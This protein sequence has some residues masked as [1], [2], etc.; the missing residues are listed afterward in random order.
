MRKKVIP[1]AYPIYIAAAVWAVCSL[2]IH[3]NTIVKLLLL[4][5][6]AAAGYFIGKMRF[7]GET[8]EVE[9]VISTGDQDTDKL[10]A[11][12]KTALAQLRETGIAINESAISAE[13]DRMDR[14]GGSILKA[15]AEKPER[16]SQVRRFMQYYLPM[17]NKLLSQ[18]RVLHDASVRGENIEKGMRSV[19]NSLDLI[20]VAFE[21]QLDVL[22][23]DEALDMSTD[24]SVL[25]T[26]IRS[27][28]LT[29]EGI[30]N[31]LKEETHNG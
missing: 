20:A 29:D 18:Y 11:D 2:F 21:K 15:V 28:G 9:E 13:L 8:I 30:A 16:A 27:D 25:E 23:K 4:A 12:S 10:L 14:A 31:I 7:P 6:L 17:A 5:L 24:V 26:L 1:S 22:Y 19:E 3:P